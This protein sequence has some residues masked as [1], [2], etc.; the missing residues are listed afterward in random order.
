M[1]FNI[2]CLQ[3]NSQNNMD[4]NI[5]RTAL[6]ITQAKS[7]GADLVTT[8]ENV[9]FMGQSA[10][11]LYEN[12]YFQEEH[13]AVLKMQELANLEKIW[14]LIGSVSV[15][16]KNS[17][18]L[19][20]RSIMIN[21][22]GDIAAA[23]DKIHLYDAAVTEGESHTES[24]RYEA[25]KKAV[26]CNTKWCDIGMTV[27][28]DLRFPH[29]FRSLAKS[30]AKVITVPSAFTRVTGQAHWHTLLRARAIE[31]ACFIVAPAQTGEHPA[32]RKTFGHSLIIDPWG[33][34]LSDA[35]ESETIIMSE[36][37]LK[38]VSDVRKQL[39]SLEHDRNFK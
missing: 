37:D 26:I 15:K 28:Y 29:L 38:V 6:L 34:I 10:K 25:G 32:N 20:N 7:D 11:E 35:G 18:K 19:A 3:T 21:A 24:K 17:E 39:P 30:G 36:I 31:N 22:K 14:I 12:S 2:A 13:P 8:P 4:Y 33:R 16:L 1:K 9:F 5:S 27:C 23:Y